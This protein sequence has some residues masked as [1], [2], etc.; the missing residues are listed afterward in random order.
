MYCKKP[1]HTI[2]NCW[3]LQA[4][5]KVKQQDINHVDQEKPDEE[6]ENQDNETVSS[7]FY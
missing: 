3:T 1:G 2:K 4:N 5:N 7:F 6:H